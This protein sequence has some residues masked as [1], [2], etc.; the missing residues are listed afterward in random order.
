MINQLYTIRNK[1]VNFDL[2]RNQYTKSLKK[3]IQIQ[4]IHSTAQY[5]Y[6]FFRA[7]I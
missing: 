2:K 7:V 3:L 5:N 4:S 1:I 6:E